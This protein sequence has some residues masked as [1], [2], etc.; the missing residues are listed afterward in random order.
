MSAA[1]FHP[2]AFDA[3]V[4]TRT[5]APW[6]YTLIDVP[7]G[8]ASGGAPVRVTGEVAGRAWSGALTPS[9]E[10]RFHILLSRRFV[11]AA[12]L[13]PGDVAAVRLRRDDPEAV[14]VPADLAA[15]PDDVPD[16]RAVWDGL[17]PGAR[18]GFVALVAPARR[19]AT[20]AARIAAVLAALESDS[21]SPYASQ[22]R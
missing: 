5:H 10:G 2:I 13:A 16:L 14:A 9:G 19:P 22:R 6:T 7:P 3:P 11:A 12:G 4:T 15:A 21:P 18:R 1:D 20:R 8:I 17:T